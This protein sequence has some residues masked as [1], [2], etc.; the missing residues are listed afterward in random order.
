MLTQL[1]LQPCPYL[2]RKERGHPKSL[3]EPPPTLLSLAGLLSLSLC[4]PLLQGTFAARQM[5]QLCTPT[6][7]AERSSVLPKH[8]LTSGK[9]FMETVPCISMVTVPTCSSSQP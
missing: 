8:R 6:S 9:D 2:L 5:G 7:C 3:C 1:V 4:E